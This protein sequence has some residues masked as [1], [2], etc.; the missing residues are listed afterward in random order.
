MLRTNKIINN[1]S[2]KEFYKE[3]YKFKQKFEYGYVREQEEPNL[4]LLRDLS[5]DDAINSEGIKYKNI[6][7]NPYISSTG[8]KNF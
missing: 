2:A 8:N 7:N 5:V 3:A 1:T 4:S 6:E